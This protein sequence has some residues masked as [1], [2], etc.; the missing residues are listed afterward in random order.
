MGTRGWIKKEEE[1]G[2]GLSLAR[3]T[4]Y[5]VGPTC[6]RGQ[7]ARGGDVDGLTWHVAIGFIGRAV[8]EWNIPIG[9]VRWVSWAA[10]P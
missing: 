7:S 6:R 9:L 5:Y 4:G 2:A 10:G 8:S 3:G 1:A